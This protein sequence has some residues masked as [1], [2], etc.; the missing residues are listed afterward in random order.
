MAQLQVEPL[1]SERGFR[2]AGELDVYTVDVLRD[3][4]AS[5]R[6]GTLVL[7]LGGVAFIDDSGLGLLVGTYKHLR[8]GGGSLVLRNMQEPIRKVFAV[9]GLETLPGLVIE[10]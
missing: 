1:E 8:Q 9:T 7:D 10:P 5:E 3:V 4:L 6:E 2:V